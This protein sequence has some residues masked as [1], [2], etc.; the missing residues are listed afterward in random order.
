MK[1]VLFAFA[2]VCAFQSFSQDTTSNILKYRDG[3]KKLQKTLFFYIT[4]NYSLDTVK[5]N[6]YTNLNITIDNKGG[7]KS[8]NIISVNDSS[9]SNVIYKAISL[10][11]GKW[12]NFTEENQILN[13]SI[14]FIYTTSDSKV[15][16][17][18]FKFYPSYYENGHLKKI[19]LYGPI[20]INFYP[21][22]R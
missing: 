16:E 18:P 10:T 21:P 2:S 6:I 8:V 4:G 14:N 5:H 19:V 15:D 1:Y 7:I 17:I 20:K 11:D 12:V 22:V 3:Y 9:I 13:L